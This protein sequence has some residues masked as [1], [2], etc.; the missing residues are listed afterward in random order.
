MEKFYLKESEF[1]A[2]CDLLKR[3]GACENGGAAKAFIE[4]GLV[5][6]NGVVEYRKRCKIREGQVIEFQNIKIEVFK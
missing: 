2:L 1:I 4:Q 6:V 5:K 3:T